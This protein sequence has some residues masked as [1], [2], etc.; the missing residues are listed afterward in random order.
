MILFAELSEAV[1]NCHEEDFW[2]FPEEKNACESFSSV[3]SKLDRFAARYRGYSDVVFLRA[4]HFEN[5]GRNEEALESYSESVALAHANPHRF[6]PDHESDSAYGP[7]YYHEM[8]ARFLERVGRFEEAIADY[9]EAL[10]ICE[11][12]W[13]EEGH[14]INIAALLSVLGRTRESGEWLQIAEEK[15]FVGARR[16]AHDYHKKRGELLEAVGR[17]DEALEEYYRAQAAMDPNDS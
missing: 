3:L 10:E 11:Y 9:Q 13:E 12:A 17:Y 1:V 15:R 16:I 6:I 4:Y 8:R 5:H 2:S 7:A 14:C